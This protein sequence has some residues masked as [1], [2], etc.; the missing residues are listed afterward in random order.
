[1]RKVLFS[2]MKNEAPFILEWLAYHKAIGFD[3]IVV[4][5]NNSD[6]G[7]TELLDAL[8][9]AGEITHIQQELAPG[10]SAQG[11]AA[12][13][14][15]EANLLQQGD[16][17]IWI[18]ADEFLNI[19]VGEGRVDDLIAAVG[20][21]HGVLIPWRLFGDGH[22]ARFEG[23]FISERFSWASAF[24]AE[25]NRE[26]KTFFRMTPAVAGL[27]QMGIHRPLLVPDQLKHRDFLNAK[28]ETL[29]RKGRFHRR[30]FR[31]EDFAMNS[32]IG[33]EDMGWDLAQIN[34]YSVRTPEYFALKRARGRGWKAEGGRNT[35]HTDE[36]YL[37]MNLND[38]Q[39]TS[40]LRFEEAVT[41]GIARLRAIPAVGEREREAIAHTNKLLQQATECTDAA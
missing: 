21:R 11:N 27:A 15:N 22:E 18:D 13:L 26:A 1:M 2:A 30:W 14:A 39:D 25:E 41:E 5:S 36:F 35:R 8:A 24:S 34:H 33:E 10:S 4:F 3:A 32:R 38:E 31:G 9:E 28:G 20:D 12:R 17:V 23:R 19:K 37:R 29:F 6:D 7:T 40:I 16:W